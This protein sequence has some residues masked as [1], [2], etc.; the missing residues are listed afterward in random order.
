[1]GYCSASPIRAPDYCVANFFAIVCVAVG[2]ASPTGDAFL[3]CAFFAFIS[4]AALLILYVTQLAA[5]FDIPWYKV[6]FGLC[7]LWI[8]F[9]IIV[10]SLTLIIWTPAYTAGAIF[11]FFAVFTYGADAFLKVK[12]TYFT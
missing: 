2:G 9:Y 12:A 10:S 7:I 8:V 3:V 11:G 1:M 5:R 4:S 6:E